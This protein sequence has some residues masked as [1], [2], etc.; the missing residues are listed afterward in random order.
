MTPREIVP[1]RKD[2][3]KDN[4]SLTVKEDM[5]EENTQMEESDQTQAEKGLPSEDS[6]SSGSVNSRADCSETE[7]LEACASETPETASET[8]MENSD[9]ATDE[10]AEEPMEQD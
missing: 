8:P 9:E 10:A 1:E 4:V 7:E 3:D 2:Q 5:S 6:E